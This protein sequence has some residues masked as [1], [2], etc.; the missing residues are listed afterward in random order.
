MDANIYRGQ[1]YVE[2]DI[3]NADDLFRL[4]KYLEWANTFTKTMFQQFFGHDNGTEAALFAL[5]TV[6][7]RTIN[8]VL[9]QVGLACTYGH[10]RHTCIHIRM[11]MTDL[12][13]YIRKDMTDIHASHDVIIH[14]SELINTAAVLKALVSEL[15]ALQQQDLVD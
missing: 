10:D 3:Q 11:D 14:R 13:V 15:L 7:I 8:D 9:E 2:F 6:L 1:V 12:H 4:H 5:E